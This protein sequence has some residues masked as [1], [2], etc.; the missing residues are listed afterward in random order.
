MRNSSSAATIIR[1]LTKN[2]RDNNSDR[3]S[4]A[5]EQSASVV[6]ETAPVLERVA[7]AMP[8]EDFD[9]RFQR[10]TETL[11][12]LL[13]GHFDKIDLHGEIRGDA[14]GR[15]EEAVRFLVMD[16]KTVSFANR[17]KEAALVLQQQ[18]LETKIE[19]LEQQRR[20][21]RLQERELAS[22]AQTIE[23]QTAAIREL[24]TPI[25]EVWEDVLVLPIVGAIDTARS[26][27]ITLELLGRISRM[28]TKWVI[29][30]ITGVEVVDTETADH[31][32]KVVRA[33]SLLGCSSLLCGVQP[34]VAQTLVSLGV[35]LLELSTARTLK[36][37]L[38][39]CLLHMRG[40]RDDD[41]TTR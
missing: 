41:R 2:A 34:A 31:L 26:Q 33:A 18:L 39:H 7:F 17:E 24:S 3:A 13:D 9:A 38:R 22:T 6:P 25:L 19:Q 29:L 12:L 14:F 21:I 23:R 1:P 16:I 10:L 28:Q 15:V 8:I 27:A 20:Q 35:E 37:A 30:D 5:A 11:T 32:L 4:M 36:D 40:R